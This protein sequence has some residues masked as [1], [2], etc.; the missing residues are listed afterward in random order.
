M[1]HFFGNLN[2]KVFAVQTVSNIT[3]ETIAKLEWL[4]GD[5]PKIE[6]TILD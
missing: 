2:T 3:Y 6:R 4:F 1:I 5:Q